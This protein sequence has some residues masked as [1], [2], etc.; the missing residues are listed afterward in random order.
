MKKILVLLLVL[1]VAGGVFAQQGEFS[2]GGVVE[3]GSYIDF[4]NS[5]ALN[6]ASGYFQP[7]DYYGPVNGN[8][9]LNYSRDAL[10]VGLYFNTFDWSS[11]GAGF[12][13]D[14]G[15]FKMQADTSIVDTDGGGLIFGSANAGRLWGYYKFVNEMVHLELAYNSRDT[16]FWASDKIGTFN[17][18]PVTNLAN[19]W[20][21]GP[22]PGGDTF[23]KVDH[24]NYLL[25]DVGLE[26]LNFGVMIPS[27]FRDDMV[28]G[29]AGTPTTTGP[30]RQAI[31]GKAANEIID[32]VLMK[33][34]VGVK[35]NMTPIEVAA[36]FRIDD[37]SVY[38]GGKWFVGPVTVGLSFMGILKTPTD[39]K[40]MKFGGGVNYDAESFGAHVNGW[41]GIDSADSNNRGTQIGIEP[42][43]TYK[44]IPTHLMFKT[45]IGFYFT[46]GK[47]GGE[48]NDIDV[49]WAVQPQLFWNFLGTG[50]SDN[51]YWPSKTGIILRYRLVS[52]ATNALDVSFRWSF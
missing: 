45:D 50:A 30:F 34:I 11:I 39:A 29:N 16:E 37:Y 33:T 36:Q 6:T 40:L 14:G 9:E 46:G 51:W 7:Y 8:F 47:T 21:A 42:G 15:N 27:L 17:G 12:E 23:T 5:P 20:G 31:S 49:N 43:F 28:H 52:D 24:H 26:N 4:E 22:W 25:T 18:S 10:R 41:Y 3:I 2:L 19:L 32:D 48:K 38:F 1:A 44:A 35:F 13:Y